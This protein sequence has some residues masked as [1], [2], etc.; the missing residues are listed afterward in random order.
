MFVCPT[1]SAELF[2]NIFTPSNSLSI[3]GGKVLQR[4]RNSGGSVRLV[5]TGEFLVFLKQ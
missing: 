3:G 2:R 4:W 5:D 1:Q